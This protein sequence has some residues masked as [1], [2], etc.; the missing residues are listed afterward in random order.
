MA[1]STG[2]KSAS[3]KSGSRA[4]TGKSKATAAETVADSVDPEIVAPAA[5]P[6]S[7]TPSDRPIET[8]SEVL[9]ADLEAP[10]SGGVV[11]DEVTPLVEVADAPKPDD[12]RKIDADPESFGATPSPAAEPEAAISDPVLP[13]GESALIDPVEPAA[14]LHGPEP[15]SDELILSSAPVSG[16]AEPNPEIEPV[17]APPAT[18]STEGAQVPPVSPPPPASGGGAMPLV[19]G[20]VFAA[21]LGAVAT[22]IVLPNGWKGGTNDELESRIAALESRPDVASA[23]GDLE[24]RLAALEQA[25]PVSVDLSPLD[26]RL[27]ALE[28]AMP[29]GDSINAAVGALTTRLAELEAAIDQR[30][31][32]GVASAIAEERAA[33]DARAEALDAQ[34]ETVEAEAARAEARTALAELIAATES[35]T[36]APEALSRLP[37]A[38]AALAPLAEGIAPLATLQADFAPAARAALAARP[39]APDASLGERVSAFFSNQTGARS[40]APRQ[41]ND[42]DAV[43]SRAEDRL[44]AGD[45]PGT[46]VELDALDGEPAAAMMEWRARAEER[47]AVMQALDAVQTQLDGE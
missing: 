44:R 17:L 13:E 29:S 2:P 5:E 12:A 38:P 36:P 37:D 11:P 40:L 7:D 24:G 35:G 14:D 20:G 3:P 25:E 46:L 31:A 26:Q 45:L 15:R 18:E 9:G 19:L 10:Q 22:L 21:V 30:V 32:E 42:V 39:I 23:T 16:E 1:R 6:S 27:A 8:P 33:V 34:A 28:Q 43:L 47:L 4:R 41:G